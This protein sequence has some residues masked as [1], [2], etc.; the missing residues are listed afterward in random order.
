MCLDSVSILC[1][2][3]DHRVRKHDCWTWCITVELRSQLM[4]LTT[5]QMNFS[6][7]WLISQVKFF[8][9]AVI[10]MCTGSVCVCVC[11]SVCLPLSM[12]VCVRVCMCLCVCLSASLHAC[13]CACVLERWWAA[14][15]VSAANKADSAMHWLQ[16]SQFLGVRCYWS[17]VKSFPHP[18]AVFVQLS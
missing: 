9:T 5:D 13:V 14:C 8:I 10:R 1:W 3:T 4:M 18:D 6:C 11:L 16:S 15:N 7:S 12:P 2:E 17:D